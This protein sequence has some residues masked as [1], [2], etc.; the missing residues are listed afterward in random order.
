M[1]VFRT[2]VAVL[3]VSFVLVPVDAA[4]KS[5]PSTKSPTGKKRP[6]T[7]AT[8]PALDAMVVCVADMK[9]NPNPANATESVYLDYVYRRDLAIAADPKVKD[10]DASLESIRDLT[11]T[12]LFPACDKYYADY[13]SGVGAADLPLSSNCPSSADFFMRSVPKRIE[14]SKVAPN[15]KA[16]YTPGQRDQFRKDAGNAVHSARTAHENARYALF[17]QFATQ[18]GARCASN[19]RFKKAFAPV[20]QRFDAN[21]A[22]VVQRETELGVRPV[23]AKN[24][25]VSYVRISDGAAI[26]NPSDI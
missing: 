17:S 26:R 24:G 2:L 15:P 23:V 5:P 12:K 25:T 4:A 13:T 10:F 22:A 16:I 20:K 21:E 18:F 9:S 3:A 7:S 8:S 14:E 19:D 1:N 11:P 6:D